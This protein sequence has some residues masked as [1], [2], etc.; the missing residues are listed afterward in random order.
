M[1]HLSRRS[2]FLGRQKCA[3]LIA[4]SSSLLLT[5]LIL[6]SNTNALAQKISLREQKTS[7]ETVLNKISKQA[8]V[9]FV[10]DS[11]LI[12]KDLIIQNINLQNAS[13]TD[14]LEAA[15]KNTNLTYTIKDKI[16]VYKLK[17][18]SPSKSTDQQSIRG[19]VLGK[20]GEPLVG[21]T[22]TIKG[23][24]QAV[25]TDEAGY[26]TLKNV[27]AGVILQISYLGYDTN[28]ISARDNL[29]VQLQQ[30]QQL[31]DEVAVSV[32]Y[33]RVAKKDLTGAVSSISGKDIEHIPAATV[34]NVLMGRVSGVHVTKA[35][36]QPGGALR[37][38]I[39]GT[40][41]ITGDNEPLYVID[42][43]PMTADAPYISNVKNSISGGEVAGGF[44]RGISPIS[45]LNLDDVL[46]ID[47][48]KDASAS[49]IYG[50]RAANG[51]VII[52][53]K[54]GIKSK[55]PQFTFDTYTGFSVARQPIVLNKEQFITYVTEAANNNPTHSVSKQILDKETPYFRNFDTDWIDEIS[56]NAKNNNIHLS[57]RG[58]NE[59]TLYY[60]SM[61]VMDQKG[62][63]LNSGFKRFAGK[64]NIEYSLSSKLKFGTNL[65][66]NYSNSNVSM[67]LSRIAYQF[68]PDFPI[69][70]DDGSFFTSPDRVTVNPVA[71]ST[72]TNVG[73]S[74]GFIGTGY[75]EAM[76]TKDLVFKSSLTYGLTNYQQKQFTPRYIRISNENPNESGTGARGYRT[77]TYNIWEN[78][79]TYHKKWNDHF[80]NMIV[81]NSFQENRMDYDLAVGSGY[82]DDLILNNLSSAALPYDVQG[83]TTG[84]G[85]VSYFAR[86]NYDYQKKYLL[87]LTSRL[88][89]SSKFSDD[90]QYG[91][92]PSGA[93]AWRVSSEKF[94]EN[95]PFVNDLKARYSLGKTGKQNIGDYLW[96]GL[97]ESTKYAN[98]GGSYP[99][100]LK[101]DKVKWEESLQQD[102]GLDF[103][104]FKNK[105]YGSFGLY[106]KV[107]T[108]L[109]ITVDMPGSSGYDRVVANVG[110]TSN[111]GWEAEINGLLIDKKDFKWTLGL[112]MTKNR[113]IVLEIGGNSFS[114]PAQRGALNDA[115][116]MEGQPL[117]TFYG[118]KVAGIFQ[119]QE[120]ID[121]LNKLAPNGLYQLKGTAPG[122]FKY[123]DLNNDGVINDKDRAPIGDANADFFGGINNSFRIKN[124]QLS[125]Q[126]NYSLGNQLIW[127]LD[128]NQ[129]SIFADRNY[130]EIVLNHWSS[131]NTNSDRPRA[132]I[133]D[134]NNN[135]RFSDYYVH[136]ASYVKLSTLMLSYNIPQP[137]YEKWGL[138]AVQLYAS[139]NNLFTLTKYP[140][141]DPEANSNPG[142]IFMGEDRSTYPPSRSFTL[143]LKFNF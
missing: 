80:V 103:S 12:N 102:L 4:K 120:E 29:K 82:P 126:I 75:L 124:W 69:F 72:S 77:S 141:V 128:Q 7:L 60:T 142:S 110:K 40:A 54:N 62:T 21:A 26:F 129:M 100:S 2:I 104:L 133:G 113:N 65:N 95:L 31:L 44:E 34:D 37:V 91:F 115:V 67:G 28:E 46:S 58:G 86:G 9:G 139:G 96:R 84:N 89:G 137:V 22:I 61:S 74:Y 122:D 8:G 121:A 24:S 49:A 87:T 51:V 108:G 135:K 53:T 93:I 55:K 71:L 36:G 76:V 90:H 79:L 117:G 70:N 39:R 123:I 83:Y 81:G 106:K 118:Y 25:K 30:S 116:V 5:A 105:V 52:T 47:V 57:V 45:N 66:Y 38:Q 11:N 97:Y 32:G 1:K 6:Q 132:V 143:G 101:N 99:S 3:N 131:S 64:T 59:S 85:L 27:S 13:L 112:V 50:S 130:S 114:N 10:G 35:D 136:D 20:N 15:F 107:T 63:E 41:S 33:G 140:G 19:Q 127:R 17:G 42:G 111:K 98:Q 109:L 78:T 43:V 48:L 125:A 68:R 88:D 56:R 18:D 73:K 138:N 14:A 16:V 94:M 92:F 119:N 23:Q 134:P